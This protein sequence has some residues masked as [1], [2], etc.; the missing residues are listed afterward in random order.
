MYMVYMPKM[1][2]LIQHVRH[3]YLHCPLHQEGPNCRK[4]LIVLEVLN[5]DYI[6]EKFIRLRKEMKKIK[7]QNVALRRKV[8]SLQELV[9]HLKEKNMLSENAEMTLLV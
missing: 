2:F 4:I 3:H 8:T 9:V 1:L 7:R 6:R 5:C